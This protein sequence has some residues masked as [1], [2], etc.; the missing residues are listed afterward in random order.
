MHAAGPGEGAYHTCAITELGGV[1]CFGLNA[2]GQLGDGSSTNR[3][4][5][6][7]VAGL[8]S[9][10]AAISAGS[11]HT[12]ALTT[13]G[14][15]KCF[16]NN[17]FGQL[18]DG[19]GT[20]R[21]TPVDVAGLISGVAAISAGTYHTCALTTGGA[22]KCFGYNAFGQLGDGS[23]TTR[24]SPV[25]V[26]GFTSGVAAIAAGAYHTCA[27]TTGGA[28]KCFGNNAYGRLGDGSTTD[29]LTPVDVT[30]LASGVGHRRRPADPWTQAAGA[31]R[32]GLTATD[33]MGP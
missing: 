10:V 4:T 25:D 28:V 19:T 33:T 29:R 21:L 15:V 20:N 8:T 1:K 23:S 7:D 32:P 2:N 17:G 5:P 12:C 9:G 26:A 14:A 30:A 13:G 18:G 22:V 31:A 27:L 16:G 6:V 11:I 3:L 24:P